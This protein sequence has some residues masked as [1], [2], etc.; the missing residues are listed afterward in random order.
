MRYMFPERLKELRLSR[1]YSQRVFGARV[2]LSAR[3]V[4]SLETGARAPS[5]SIVVEICETYGVTADWLC[6]RV[7]KPDMVW[8]PD[9]KESMDLFFHGRI[10]RDDLECKAIMTTVPEYGVPVSA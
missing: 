6:G 1:C 9:F 8:S 7:D 10:C 2:G 3:R 4:S 5:L